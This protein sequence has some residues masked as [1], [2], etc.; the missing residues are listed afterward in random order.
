MHAL[1]TA[2]TPLLAQPLIVSST[3]AGQQWNVTL[4]AHSDD[5]STEPPPVRNVYALVGVF[6]VAVA[7]ICLTASSLCLVDV[8][9]LESTR[10]VCERPRHGASPTASPRGRSDEVARQPSRAGDASRKTL[11][12]L[13]V[14]ALFVLNGGRDALLNTLLFTYVDEYLGWIGASSALLVTTYHVTRAAVHAVLTAL[15]SHGWVQTSTTLM[16][17]FNVVALVISSALMLLTALLVHAGDV[18]TSVGVIVS[19]LA[20]S[21]M[22]RTTV[23]LVDQQVIAPPTGM[24]VFIAAIGVGEIVVAPLCGRLLQSAGAAS[25][26]ALLLALALAELALFSVYC[27]L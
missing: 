27:I 21:N 6:D 23:D 8:V 18:L 10:Q 12:L 16:M 13:V 26:P 15:Q 17:M 2:L 24:A 1:G 19:A 4:P 25:F 9:P 11:L 22:H 3:A 20:T 5:R 14:M 7:F